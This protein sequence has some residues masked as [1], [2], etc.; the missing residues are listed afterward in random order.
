VKRRILILFL[1][2]L[3]GLASPILAT[4]HVTE[5]Y[6]EK[7]PN[8]F[9]KVRSSA[10]YIEFFNT[11]TFLTS[12]ATAATTISVES[13]T[14]FAA[15][16]HVYVGTN[17]A[18]LVASIPGATSI[19]LATA[20]TS[21]AYSA[22]VLKRDISASASADDYEPLYR[23]SDSGTSITQPFRADTYGMWQFWIDVGTFGR[24]VSTSTGTTLS[25]T[26]EVSY[27]VA[28]AAAGIATDV[29]CVGSCVALTSET[30]GNYVATVA[31]GTAMDVAEADGEGVTKTPSWDST[32]V[33]DTT[34][35]AA[36]TLPFIWTFDGS[37]YDVLQSIETNGL[38]VGRSDAST[39]ISVTAG[40]TDSRGSVRL[41]D[42]STHYLKIRASSMNADATF[43]M[44]VDDG[45]VGQ[46]FQTDGS[47]VLT[48][49]DRFTTVF[50]PS[51][52]SVG[53]A[54]FQGDDDLTFAVLANTTYSFRITIYYT[55]PLGANLKVQLTGP[56]SP[57]LVVYEVTAVKPGGSTVSPAAVAT[58]FG[59]DTTG[60]TAGTC[61]A[62]VGSSTLH[63]VAHV[64]GILQN[65][66]N[67]GSITVSWAQNS[68]SGT[69]QVFAGSFVEWHRVN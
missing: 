41:S 49:A 26:N 8:G 32:E 17:A 65:G 51:D 14:G 44:P 25:L 52:E 7:D 59:T 33:E 56:A 42:G 28:E 66:A 13:S 6:F 39:E 68:Q 3:V 2:A 1:A 47:G 23:D 50:K 61:V 10:P 20:V 57:T 69:S 35:G 16:D 63:G 22:V 46:T 30:S 40:D 21:A 58:A 15:G 18:V 4:V 31:A 67:A 36:A 27:S 19:T 53:N 5:Q 38:T 24:R 45:V 12:A 55:T 29:Q 9:A 43:D 54:T 37:S 64:T 34:W 62:L 48:W 60:C 11:S